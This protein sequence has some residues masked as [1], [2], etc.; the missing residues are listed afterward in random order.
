MKK[1]NTEIKGVFIIEPDVHKDFRGYFIETYNKYIMAELGLKGEFVQD[2]MSYTAKKGTIRGLH[3][4]KEPYAQAKLVRCTK[5]SVIDVA[6]D[7]RKGSSTYGKWT[8]VELTDQN[9]KMFYL[10]RGMA[11]GFLTLTDDVEFQYKCDNEY[12]KG[13]E[14]SVRYDDKKLAIPWD[15]YL[16]G[17]EPILSDKDRIA[18]LLKDCAANFI[19]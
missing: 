2:N 6:V 16:K 18:P 13:S 12:M 19:Y 7:L 15:E 14:G 17:L 4:Q 8:W 1:S 5:G 11:H 3:F 9:K 10:P